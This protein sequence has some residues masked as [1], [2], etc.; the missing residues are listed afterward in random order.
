MRVGREPVVRAALK[1]MN[2]VG[3]DGL[4]LRAIAAELGVRAPTL[5]WR[6]RD[7]QDLVDEMASQVLADYAEKLLTAVEPGATWCD[8]TRA[9]SRAFRDELALYRDGARMVAGT[10]LRD[11]RVY[12]VMETALAIFTAAGVAP[13]DAAMFLK[14]VHD[15]IIG[16]M[17]E[18]QAVI[19][20]A[21]ARDPRYD[22]AERDARMDPDRYPLA[23]S[24]GPELFDNYD[25]VF[26][27]GLAFIVRGFAASLP[28]RGQAWRDFRAGA[29]PGGESRYP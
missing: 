20:P 2:D 27:R 9:S 17:I 28:R 16:S 12:A 29:Y 1:L 3:L 18:Q 21:G 11:S 14:T 13:S 7:R 19:S 5:Y 22:L 8:W 26:E 6:F 4:T 15:F 10:Q 25:A 24:I 23:R